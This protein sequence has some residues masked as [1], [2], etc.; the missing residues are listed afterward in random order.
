[1]SISNHPIETNP[2]IITNYLQKRNL[3]YNHDFSYFSNLRDLNQNDYGTPDGWIYNDSGNGGK[4]LFFDNC[5]K[6]ITGKGESIK[7]TFQQALHE[8]PRW[9]SKL[10]GKVITAKAV[11]KI[12]DLCQISLSL[13]DGI[14]K[15]STTI[16]TQGDVEL[17][18][19]L[20]VSNKAKQVII[21]IESVTPNVTINIIKVFANIGTEALENLP[22]IVNGFIGELKQ[23]IFTDNPPPEELSLCCPP[24]Q[25]NNNY[26]RLNSVV[27]NKFGKTIGDT[28]SILPDLR[29]L[30]CRSW[31]NGSDKDP[32]VANRKTPGN[33]KRAGD[34]V[35]TVQDDAFK[36]HDHNLTYSN[37]GTFKTDAPVN[38]IGT[39]QSTTGKTGGKETRPKNISVLY[40]IKWA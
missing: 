36:E 21:L 20:E 39:G 26:T 24:K 2:E 14:S 5:C 11:M 1:M 25:L 23:Y 13:K 12:D 4:L 29:G 15:N 18:V 30:F 17:Q 27:N 40:T 33:E 22:C 34:L 31:N 38:L 28:Y 8:F 3:V 10:K 6:I 19:E 32:D 7:M 37:A 35:G 16:T 9:E